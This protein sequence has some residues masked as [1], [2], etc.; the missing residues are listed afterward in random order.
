LKDAVEKR[1]NGKAQKRKILLERKKR[2]KTHQGKRLLMTVIKG[3]G[4]SD[5]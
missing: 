5:K 1:K 2:S 3:H 4:S